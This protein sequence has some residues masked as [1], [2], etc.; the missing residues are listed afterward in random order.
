MSLIH[1]R[2]VDLTYSTRQQFEVLRKINLSLEPQDFVC[3]IG[4]SGCGKT[5]IL[6]IIAG[7]V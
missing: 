6:R 2:S 5:S 7:S 3:V 4:S 1:L